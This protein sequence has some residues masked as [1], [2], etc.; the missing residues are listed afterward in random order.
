MKRP[1]AIGG[2]GSTHT[3]M[4]NQ[5]VLKKP[6]EGISTPQPSIVA[7]N[8]LY[9]PV[10]NEPKVKINDFSTSQS[11]S[12]DEAESQALPVNSG[13]NPQHVNGIDTPNGNLS[14][15]VSASNGQSEPSVQVVSPTN[16]SIGPN[17]VTDQDKAG[18]VRP[19]PLTIAQKVDAILNILARYR[20][21]SA[22]NK[23]RQWQ[24]KVTVA[25][26]VRRYLEHESTIRL[27]LPAFPFK[28]PNKI[29]KVI[30]SLP[31]KAEEVALMHLNSLCV[32]I[33]EIHTPGAEISIV[34]DGL[35]YSGMTLPAVSKIAS[36]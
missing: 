21:N 16:G 32:M 10:K 2:I 7:E 1:I 35:M 14:A 36:F 13:D 23:R 25:S 22:A 31:D 5:N 34:S 26:Q 6:N 27:V 12:E 4:A 17:A 19:P 24:G 11:Q 33:K 20:I 9:F 18:A 8:Q 15:E 29:S 30:G 3:T 28:S